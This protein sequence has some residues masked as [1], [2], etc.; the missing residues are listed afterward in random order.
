MPIDKNRLYQKIMD[1]GCEVVADGIDA[2]TIRCKCGSQ[3]TKPLKTLLQL[4]R[5]PTLR[6]AALQ[7]EECSSRWTNK[8]VDELLNSRN[9]TYSRIT[10][11]THVKQ[12]SVN[13][14]EWHCHQCTNVWQAT[15]DQINQSSSGCPVCAGNIPYTVDSLQHKINSHGLDI[16]VLAIHTRESSLEHRKGLFAC[17][18]GHEWSASIHNIL[19]FHYGCPYCN[20]NMSK[21]IQVDN[22][23]FHSK[24][25]ALAYNVF[26]GAG[27][28]FQRQKRYN[29]QRR[30][31]CDFYFP[32]SQT[33]VEVSGV[34]LLKWSKYSNSIEAKRRIVE[35]ELGQRFLVLTSYSEFLNFVNI[36]KGD[37]NAILSYF[38]DATP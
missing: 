30:F 14:I 4:R 33:W 7:C 15:M 18:N 24:L 13:K 11:V 32:S 29:K 5:S 28:T 2:W 23:R 34:H 12:P 27:L 26:T 21:P 35:D 31:K 6:G 37:T 3:F 38:P 17:S 20:Y 22:I 25:E 36:T 10:D 1:R 9:A 19:K 8:K 16:R